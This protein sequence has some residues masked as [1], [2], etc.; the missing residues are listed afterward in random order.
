MEDATRV[1]RDQDAHVVGCINLLLQNFM[2]YEINVV[3]IEYMYIE[4]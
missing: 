4:T 1:G 3:Q 2:A